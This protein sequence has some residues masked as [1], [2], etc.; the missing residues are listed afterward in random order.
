[1]QLDTL[2]KLGSLALEVAQDDKVREL[3][4]MIHRGARRRGILPAPPII[5]APPAAGGSASGAAAANAKPSAAVPAAPKSAAPK[6]AAPNPAAPESAAAPW[7]PFGPPALP[8]H[9]YGGSGITRYLTAD[10]A[11]KALQLAGVV[12]GLL[13]K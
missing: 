7:I 12:R 6:S 13:S 9:M 2:V 8:M 1:M 5:P 3:A 10:N 11:K 4:A